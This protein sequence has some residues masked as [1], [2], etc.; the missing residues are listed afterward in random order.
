MSELTQNPDG[1]DLPLISPF[2]RWMLAIMGVMGFGFFAYLLR[3][4]W[5]SLTGWIPA[6]VIGPLC[7]G[8]LFYVG[9]CLIRYGGT[10]LVL[11]GAGIW[12][13]GREREGLAWSNVRGYEL[14]TK[15]FLTVWGRD[16]QGLHIPSHFGIDIGERLGPIIRELDRCIGP[17]GD[18]PTFEPTRNDTL[19]RRFQHY[20]GVLPA[21]ELEPGVVYRYV[22]SDEP[23]SELRSAMFA[24]GCSMLAVGAVTALSLRSFG[25]L[26]ATLYALLAVLSL[27]GLIRDFVFL[28]SLND[29]FTLRDGQVWVLRNGQEFPLPPANEK[30]G[31][32]LLKQPTTTHGRGPLAYR[33]APQL[34]EPDV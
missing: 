17:D 12:L 27:L 32:L 28:R 4:A 29:R 14:P 2:S 30:R 13:V 31:R 24:N 5:G 21:V 20:Y 15:G 6:S 16:G 3:M 26:F 19:G 18:R 8:G 23:A 1:V 34:L 22:P 33:M 7:L 25:G 11:D 10:R 9:F